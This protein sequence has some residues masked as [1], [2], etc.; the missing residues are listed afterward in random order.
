MKTKSRG[1]FSWLFKSHKIVRFQPVILSKWRMMLT[2]KLDNHL[3]AVEE[4]AEKRMTMLMKELTER[5]PAPDKAGNQIAWVTHRNNLT[6]MA[7]ECV[8][9]E[10]VYS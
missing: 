1:N 7:E 2:G 4:A 10:L 9:T 5:F 3:V 6:A 8:L